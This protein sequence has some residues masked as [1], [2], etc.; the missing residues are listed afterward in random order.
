MFWDDRTLL[1][2]GRDPNVPATNEDI[3]FQ[4]EWE[5]C[6]G[7]SLYYDSILSKELLFND[8]SEVTSIKC[9]KNTFKN[10][11]STLN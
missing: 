11:E 4:E 6:D 3:V 5:I 7:S 10:V 1:Q 8:P 2:E 9:Y